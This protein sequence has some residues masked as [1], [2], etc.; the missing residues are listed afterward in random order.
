MPLPTKAKVL[1]GSTDKPRSLAKSEPKFPVP[2]TRISAEFCP[3][4]KPTGTLIV[5]RGSIVLSPALK[6]VPSAKTTLLA[7]LPK[8][9]PP[10]SNR[11]LA[12]NTMPLGLIKIKLALPLAL[13]KPSIFDT[14]L[15]VTRPTILLISVALLKKA[16]P[17]V[18]TENS[19]KLWNRFVSALVPP[20]ISVTLSLVFV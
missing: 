15:P 12:P 1:P 16:V 9:A 18:S 11:A 17:P 7:L 4:C 13:I 6:V 2:V 10:I 20:V 19:P 8:N 14:S 5:N 3:S